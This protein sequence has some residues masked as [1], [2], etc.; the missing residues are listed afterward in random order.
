MEVNVTAERKVNSAL[1][2]GWFVDGDTNRV[3]ID[4]TN[5]AMGQKML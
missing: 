5:P 3:V 1:R 2:T 4:A